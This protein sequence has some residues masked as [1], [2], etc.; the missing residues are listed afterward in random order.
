MDLLEI[1]LQSQ[2]HKVLLQD[3]KSQMLSH[4]YMINSKDEFYLHQLSIFAAKDIFCEENN[5]PCENCANCIK[6]N[7]SN[8]VDLM[9]YPKNDKKLMVDDIN[10]I[11]TD[12]YIRPMSSKY[13]IYVL[14]NFDESTVQAQNKI[15]KT[16][17]EPPT[18]VIFI[19]TCKNELKVLPTILSRSKK[20]NEIQIDSRLIEKYLQDIVE[21][22]F[23]IKKMI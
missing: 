18:N 22:I 12:C 14:E 6:I 19:L 21:K 10:E 4:C 2:T 1:Y 13:K 15:L 3:K 5:S 7:H 23:F 17:E 11:V 20:V 16:L 9:F 8:M